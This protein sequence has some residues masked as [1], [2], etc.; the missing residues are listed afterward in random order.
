[1]RYTGIHTLT[2]TH[3]LSHTMLK[4]VFKCSKETLIIFICIYIFV[5]R[6]YM[7]IDVSG[8]MLMS[9]VNQPGLYKV[10]SFSE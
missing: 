1:M 6:T 8:E 2:L 3:F 9:V 7:D 4:I 5:M 10:T